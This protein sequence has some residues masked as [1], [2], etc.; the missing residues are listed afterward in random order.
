MVNSDT[1]STVNVDYTLEPFVITIMGNGNAAVSPEDIQKVFSV[2]YNYTD[3][4]YIERVHAV[5][6][7]DYVD[8]SPVV[9]ARSS[10]TLPD[11]SRTPMYFFGSAS[12]CD[13][14]G[15]EVDMTDG[16]NKCGTT[17][18]GK[19]CMNPD[20][21]YALYGN[22]QSAATGYSFYPGCN[23][24]TT[25]LLT[26]FLAPDV[27]A[28]GTW[29]QIH[30]PNPYLSC[31]TGEL[32]SQDGWGSSPYNTPYNYLSPYYANAQLLADGTYASM[33]YCEKTSSDDCFVPTW[34]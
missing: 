9:G 29:G 10:S 33:G 24:T 20:G 6:V 17:A 27:Y 32:S 3:Y 13:L 14:G 26:I 30:S 18:D 21:N 1:Y 31:A 28:I 34:S 5:L 22:I 8:N 19:E 16:F 2:Y 25:N 23:D 4:N 11:D 7:K 12:T 15:T